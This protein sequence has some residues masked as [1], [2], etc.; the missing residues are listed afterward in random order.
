MYSIWLLEYAHVNNQPIGS[1]LS[2]QHNKGYREL[3]F[4][5]MLLKGHGHNILIDTGTDGNSDVTKKLHVRDD[6]H[7]WQ[8]PEKILAKTGVTPDDIDYVI[9]THAHY[10]H[11]DNLKAFKNAKF[12]IQEKELLGWVWAMTR[13]KRFR[14]PHMALKTEN[15][16]E[17]LKL[18]EEERMILIDGE[19]KD[20]LPNIDLYP[21]YDGHSFASQIVII[22]NS[23][24]KW[25]N[26]G[27]L[28]YVDANFEG[29]N[30]DGVYVPVGLGVG[31]PYNM[32]RSLEDIVRLADGKREQIIIGHETSNWERFPSRKY[33]DGLW[34]AEICRD[35]GEMSIFDRK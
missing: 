18:T 20:V 32:T 14:A 16:Y 11:M 7:G 23:D 30:G 6:V 35:S 13:P 26:I 29:I 22:K 1:V 21:A 12:I 4:T 10:D 9:I 28:A 5:Y 27:D 2:G 3:S 19:K 34:V 31:N 24:T 17:A 15:I 33:D 25:L 8:P